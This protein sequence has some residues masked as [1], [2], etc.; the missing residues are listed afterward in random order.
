MPHGSARWDGTG[1]VKISTAFTSTS[2]GTAWINLGRVRGRFS[3]QIYK[4]SAGTS[5][6]NVQLQGSLTT[7][8]TATPRTLII[9]TQAANGSIVSST[10]FFPCQYIRV[11]STTLGGTTAKR[12]VIWAGAA[13]A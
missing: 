4:A 1:P 5:N 13:P 3:L 8:T 6:W 2:A 10:A 12:L 9:H 7:Q 11:K